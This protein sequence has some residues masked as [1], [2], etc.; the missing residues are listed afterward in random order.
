[1]R[2]EIIR[3]GRF[4]ILKSKLRICVSDEENSLSSLDANSLCDESDKEL[5]ELSRLN[6]ENKELCKQVHD[7]VVL[8]NEKS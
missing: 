1:M 2:L 4:S 7:H 8:E 6:H 5:S 3:K